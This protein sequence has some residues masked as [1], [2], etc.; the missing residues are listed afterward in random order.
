MDAP[1]KALNPYPLHFFVCCYLQNPANIAKLEEVSLLSD[2]HLGAFSLLITL[3]TDELI[4]YTIVVYL[5][6]INWSDNISDMLAVINGFTYVKI[7]LRLGI[8]TTVVTLSCSE[9]T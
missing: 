5:M 1:K 2:L 3:L 9:P 4:I 7:V 6:S 8:A